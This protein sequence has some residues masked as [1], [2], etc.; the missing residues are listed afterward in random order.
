MSSSELFSTIHELGQYIAFLNANAQTLQIGAGETFLFELAVSHS[1]LRRE[2]QRSF[3]LYYTIRHVQS[4]S[5]KLVL[6]SLNNYSFYSHSSLRG[7]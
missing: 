7:Y 3:Y 4:M 5:Q 6:N 1:E 2:M